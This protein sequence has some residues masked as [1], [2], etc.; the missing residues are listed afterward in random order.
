LRS[1]RVGLVLGGGGAAGLA[2]H[3]GV[4]WALHHDLGWDPHAAD[5]VVGTSAGSIAGA[6]LRADVP[7]EDLAAWATDADPSRRG[8]KFRA[9][10][11]AAESTVTRPAVPT[12]TLPGWH[13]LNTLRHPSQLPRA[14]TTML[15]HG[16]LDHSPRMAALEHLA[17]AWPSNPLW[18]SAVRVGD[19]RVKWFGRDPSGRNIVTPAQAVAASCAIPVVARPVRIGAHRYVDGGVKSPTNA[20]VLL[21]AALD[22][23][24]VL[25]PMGQQAGRN[26]L[27]S[28]ADRRV[29]R[30]A[31]ELRRAGVTVQVLSPDADTVRVMGHNMLDRN[32]IGSVMRHAF[33]GATSQIDA[34]TAA[35]LRGPSALHSA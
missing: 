19:G 12:P 8:R 13:T 15:P 34:S 7:V 3:A 17:P 20:D 24:I 23:V 31:A 28:L 25:S 4:L 21:D 10:M 33:L 1:P 30:E 9:M 35:M 14:I 11:V 26:A 29:R 5:I 22:L 2:F 16:L 27:R 18:I 32:R 6:L